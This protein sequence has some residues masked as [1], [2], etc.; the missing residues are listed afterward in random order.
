MA[1]DAL[2][3]LLGSIITKAACAAHSH[4]RVNNRLITRITQFRKAVR[5]LPHAGIREGFWR[6]C[7][8]CC[9][10][11]EAV[12]A[13]CKLQSRHGR[14][15]PAAFSSCTHTLT[16]EMLF[17]NMR[18]SVPS[19]WLLCVIHLTGSNPFLLAQHAEGYLA[20]TASR[21]S[22]AAS[23]RP[24]RCVVGTATLILITL[25]LRCCC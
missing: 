10:V 13:N 21:A 2:Q 17:L 7:P 22:N 9:P 24:G 15:G 1:G 5:A 19:I 6:Q 11:V 14:H 16:K 23:H 12:L 25:L 4:A 8:P 20:S 18:L 3:G